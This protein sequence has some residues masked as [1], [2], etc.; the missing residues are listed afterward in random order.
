[1]GIS[2]PLSFQ[3]ADTL[4]CTAGA[5]PG[6]HAVSCKLVTHRSPPAPAM[7]HKSKTRRGVQIGARSYLDARA[8]GRPQGREAHIAAE[9]C[10]ILPGRT[11][12]AAVLQP[13]K[14]RANAAS[15]KTGSAGLTCAPT[16]L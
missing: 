8:T 11:S 15:T 2:A 3:C 12:S 6:A 14:R 9:F 10:R 4:P 16:Q 7:M 1:M 13:G 5:K